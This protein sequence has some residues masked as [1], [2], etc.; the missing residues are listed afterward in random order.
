MVVPAR[1]MTHGMA[2]LMKW[3]VFLVD[4][5]YGSGGLNVIRGLICAAASSKC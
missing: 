1:A 3:K 4:E 5:E 2:M